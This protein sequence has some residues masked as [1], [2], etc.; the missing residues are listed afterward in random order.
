M[1]GLWIFAGTIIPYTIISA[2]VGL[3]YINLPPEN[4]LPISSLVS[5]NKRFGKIRVGGSYQLLLRKKIYMGYEFLFIRVRF[6]QASW[7]H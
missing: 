6:D 2:A 4:E 5:E 1:C 3:V 7:L